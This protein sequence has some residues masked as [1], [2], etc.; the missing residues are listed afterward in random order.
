MRRFGCE[1]EDGLEARV[2]DR[3][4]LRARVQLDAARSEVDA[5]LGLGQGIVAVE[6]EAHEGDQ[7]TVALACPRE[8]AIVRH[9]VGR[10]ALRI[11]QREHECGVDVVLLHRGEVLL[12]RQRHP[13]LVEPQVRV[14]VDDGA[15]LRQLLGERRPV[16]VEQAQSPLVARGRHDTERIGRSYPRQMAEGVLMHAESIAQPDQLVASR[17]LTGDPFVYMEVGGRRLIAVGDF[18][19]GRATSESGADEVWSYSDLGIT[20]LYA[21]GIDRRSIE[22]ELALRAARRAGLDAVVVPGWFP[23][24]TAEHLRG[25]GIDVR[26][27]DDRFEQRRRLKD[28]HAIAAIREVTLLVEDSM[29][30]IRSRLAACTVGTDGTLGDDGGVLT[31]ERLH[32]AVR[33]FWA[34]NGLEGELP[35]IAGGAH[36]ADPHD[37]G[38]GPLRACTPILC[39]LFPRSARSRYHGDMTRTFCV[40]E[41]PAELVELHATVER[42]LDTAISAIRP[43][44]TGSSVDALVCALFEAEGHPT[45]RSPAG[46]DPCLDR[47]LHPRP[48]ARRRARRPR[49]SGPRARR[50]RGAAG[51]RRAH[52]RAGPL[53]RRLRG[54]AARGHRGRHGGRLR[55]PEPA[56]SITLGDRLTR[57]PSRLAVAGALATVYIVWGST[58]LG[59]EEAGRTLPTFLML[60]ARFTI[61][62]PILL[63]LALRGGTPRPTLVEWRSSAIVGACLLCGALGLVTIAEKRVPTGVAALMVGATPLWLALLDRLWRGVRLRA[64]AI[65]GL[66][67]GFAGVAVLAWPSG[68]GAYD[69][70]GMILLFCSPLCWT[71]GSI[72]ARGAPLPARPLLGAACQM[73]T[74]VPILLVA[75]VLHGELGRLGD[76][77]PSWRSIVALLYLASI[78]SLAGY[79]AYVWLLASAPVSLVGTYAFVNPVVA[80]LLGYLFLDERITPR[81]LAAAVVIVI[82]VALIV[83]GQGRTSPPEA[84][85]T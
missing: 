53:P 67:V 8:H 68:S 33:S 32:A 47:P 25:A 70:T 26:I 10:E 16:L 30:L 7:A 38:S 45:T 24:A 56:R 12:E 76:V 46:V 42:A 52:G 40:G 78:G 9:A 41:P 64:V 61:A 62:G 35:I 23:L 77:H 44:V 83:S 2:G 1:R 13:V 39:D 17:F 15:G 69:R 85:H 80:V 49:G 51:R 29:R 58:F 4:G 28:A 11:V 60:S 3:E 34:E 36:A 22:R 50:T 5:A 37:V 19:V 74:A 57:S 71:V 54:R 73:T 65:V 66:A 43:G 18:E 6:R 20:E 75:A 72:Y 79:S 55:E 27:D 82:A 48:R 21:S 31:S 59:L 63:V 14:R 84:E 81:V